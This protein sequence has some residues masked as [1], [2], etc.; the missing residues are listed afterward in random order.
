[1]NVQDERMM[2]A[3]EWFMRLREPDVDESTAA[4]WLQWSQADRANLA[5]FE[6]VRELWDRF[7]DSRLHG[8]LAR[9]MTRRTDFRPAAWAIAA[10]TILAVGVSSWWQFVRSEHPA[11]TEALNTDAGAMRRQRLQDGSIVELGARSSAHVRITRERR[12]IFVEDGEAFFQVAKDPNRPF[13]VRAGDL[14][15]VAVGTAFKVRKTDERVVVT[16][17]E[18]AVRVTPSRQTAAAIAP[19]E[20]AE[21][22]LRAGA[23]HQV[24]Y[25]ARQQA[26]TMTPFAPAAA[27]GAGWQV[28][29]F[30]FVNEPLGSVIADINRYSPRRI[31]LADER[32]A[33]L[34]FTGTLRRDAIDD[35]LRGLRDVFPVEVVDR[36]ELGVLLAER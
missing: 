6:R 19:A 15:V 33:A 36:G 34:V 11:F 14:Q 12:E 3:S 35:W 10:S 18:G 29:R 17:K 16:V 23:G 8:P 4:G 30:E 9:Q 21:G 5:A 1:M 2:Q 7:D 31:A 25:S 24:T 27:P 20:S 26:L 28:G 22:Q 32:I 13:V